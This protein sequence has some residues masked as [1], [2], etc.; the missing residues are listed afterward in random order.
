MIVGRQETR[1][2]ARLVLYIEGAQFIPRVKH[3]ALYLKL[4]RERVILAV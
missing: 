4:Q 3:N 1:G 2:K